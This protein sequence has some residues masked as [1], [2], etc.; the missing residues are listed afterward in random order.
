[1]EKSSF[2]L[3]HLFKFNFLEDLMKKTIGLLSGIILIFVLVGQTFAADVAKIGIINFQKIVA[4]SS[5]GKIA[6]KQLKNEQKKLIDKIN[7][8]RTQ[9]N[10]FFKSL[11]REKLVLSQEQLS[12]KEREKRIKINDLKKMQEDSS[13]RLKKL[14]Y[15]LFS[16]IQKKVFEIAQKIGKEQGFLLILEKKQAGVIY[17]PDNIDITDRI[18]KTFNIDMAKIKQ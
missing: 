7:S 12:A 10:E 5:A 15:D 6:Q 16:K 13:K 3:V 2:L 18:I 1:M 8:E 9:L 11:E 14:E 17:H 4:Q